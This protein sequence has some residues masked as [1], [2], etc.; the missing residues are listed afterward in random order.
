MLVNLAK[1]KTGWKGDP[2]VEAGFSTGSLGDRMIAVGH[3]YSFAVVLD[4]V[5]SNKDSG[6]SYS[7]YWKDP[8]RRA[9]PSDLFLVGEPVKVTDDD[10]EIYPVLAQQNGL[11]IYCS[12]ELIQ[13]VISLAIEQKPS[14]SHTELIECIEYYLQKDTFL[15]LV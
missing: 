1:C 10:D 3:F 7:L 13:D 4:A 11:W 6:L 5:A 14:A 9:E 8:D 2:A 15:D 12:D